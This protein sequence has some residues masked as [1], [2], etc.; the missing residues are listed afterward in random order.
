MHPAFFSIQHSI[1]RNKTTESH[2]QLTH[3]QYMNP[4][5]TATRPAT[6]P[7]TLCSPLKFAGDCDFLVD[8]GDPADAVPELTAFAVG[9]DPAIKVA[10]TVGRV[11]SPSTSQPPDVELG[12][13]GAVMLGL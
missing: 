5:E 9:V 2:Q 6:I 8:A 10:P 12:H 3:N 1:R 7:D 13:A 4:S 11:T